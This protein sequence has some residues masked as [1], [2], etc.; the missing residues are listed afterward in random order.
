MAKSNVE[1]TVPISQTTW[2][3]GVG[4]KGGGRL[5]GPAG[6]NY[7]GWV[8]MGNGSMVQY[9]KGR[10]TGLTRSQ[11]STSLP[12][13]PES[14]SPNGLPNMPTDGGAPAAPNLKLPPELQRAASQYLAGQ[15]QLAASGRRQDYA[16]RSAF[17]TGVTRATGTAADIYGGRAPAIFGQALTGARRQERQQAAAQALSQADQERALRDMYTT[18]IGEQ[19]Q[20]LAQAAIDDARRRAENMASIRTVGA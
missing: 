15:A 6:K 2:K 5:T 7:T 8:D 11:S 12:N 1:L 9:S 16:R 19:Y 3:T 4:P 14:S 13:M 17:A 10:K 20:G 18:A